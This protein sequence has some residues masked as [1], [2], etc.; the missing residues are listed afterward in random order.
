MAN[1]KNNKVP[2]RLRETLIFIKNLRFACAGARG[3]D[4]GC[5]KVGVSP[6]RDANFHFFI[7]SDFHKFAFRLRETT[8]GQTRM[9]PQQQQQKSFLSVSPTPNDNFRFWTPGFAL[10]HFCSILQNFA[11]RLRQMTTLVTTPS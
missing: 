2:S 7:F 10:L 8:P 6:A 9:H 1:N 3:A 4:S 11:S 5:C